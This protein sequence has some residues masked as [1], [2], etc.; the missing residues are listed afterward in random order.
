MRA[1]GAATACVSM[2]PGAIPKV[3]RSWP[4]SMHWPRSL[5]LRRP[6]RSAITQPACC[7]KLARIEMP[8]PRVIVT[9][10]EREAA[11]WVQTLRAAGL[12][13]QA[14][15]L[16]AIAPVTDSKELQEARRRVGDYAALMFVSAAAAEHFFAD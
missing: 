8:V 3:P 6:P 11:R 16:I 4:V 2:R 5:I 9:R 13:A 15:P 14:L 1:G 7:A 10:P 12:D